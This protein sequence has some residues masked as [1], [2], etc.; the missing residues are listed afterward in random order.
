MLTGVALA[1]TEL[2]LPIEQVLQS[3]RAEHWLHNHPDAPPEQRQ[4]IKRH[5]RDMFYVDADDWKEMVCAQ[6]HDACMKA[7]GRL[8]STHAHA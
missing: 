8:A 1:L 4:E 5:L 6:A 3:F 7:V 2:D